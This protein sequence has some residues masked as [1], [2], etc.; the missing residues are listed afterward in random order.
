V[1]ATKPPA[2]EDPEEA[3]LAALAG[4]G[5]TARDSDESLAH[6]A[7]SL[8]RARFSAALREER[9]APDSELTRARILAHA[10][11][12]RGRRRW[13]DATLAGSTGI[14]AGFVAAALWLHG[15]TPT[16]LP[17]VTGGEMLS[18][19]PDTKTLELAPERRYLIHSRD[20]AATAA[21]LAR[22]FLRA[23]A[24]LKMQSLA[25]G[26]VQIDIEPLAQVSPDLAAIGARLGLAIEGGE[27][28][29]FT[30]ESP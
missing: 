2:S 19:P 12:G 7:G 29:R 1:S 13:L 6:D 27:S 16:L 25:G 30:I 4:R 11:A 9:A 26:Q 8:I 24:S 10:R 3:W 14:A 18:A 20:V 23:G 22:H 28:L 21:E 17:A 15:A 5:A